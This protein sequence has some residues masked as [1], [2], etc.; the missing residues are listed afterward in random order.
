MSETT[1]P[2]PRRQRP[3]P[4]RSCKLSRS[5]GVQVLTLKVGKDV[6]NYFLEEIGAAEGRGFQLTR[7]ATEKEPEAI[8]HVN[9]NDS[10]SQH[11]CDCKGFCR[12]GHCKHADSLL[13]LLQRGKLPTTAPDCQPFPAEDLDIDED[14]DLALR[15]AE[16]ADAEAEAWHSQY[17]AA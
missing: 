13:A 8:Y 6:D 16:A 4:P 12:W 15:E 10:D 17:D 5:A 7:I 11:S 2:R 14:A 9:L 3:K 1:A